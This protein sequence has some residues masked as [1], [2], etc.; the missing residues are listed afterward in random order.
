MSD[1]T[2]SNTLQS[3]KNKCKKPT[4]R[5]PVNKR[6][7]E[8]ALELSLAYLAK[9]K[10]KPSMTLKEYAEFSG[11]DIRQ[12]QSDANRHYLPLRKKQ[13]PERRELLQVN[14]VALYAI[15]FV[16]G[17]EILENNL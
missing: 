5:R 6:S 9:N 14:M 8:E 1:P 10:I 13:D 11:Q 4:Q 7:M 2:Q 15:P 17:K 12:V 16:E 3:K